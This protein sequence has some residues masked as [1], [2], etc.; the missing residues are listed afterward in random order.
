MTRIIDLLQH[1]GVLASKVRARVVA[2]LRR[3]PRVVQICWNGVVFELE[4][5]SLLDEGD[6]A[7]MACRGYDAILQRL[8]RRH[9]RHGDTFVD[10]GANVG[11]V[12]AFASSLVGSTGHVVGIEPLTE[13]YDRLVRLEEMNPTRRLTFVKGAAGEAEGTAQ[14][15]LNPNGDARNATLAR[16]DLPESRDVR[17]LRLDGLLSAVCLDVRKVSV[18]KID[19]EGFELSVIKGL[20]GMLDHH[21]PIM[22]CEL[23]PWEWPSL[24]QSAEEF[25]ALLRHYSYATEDPLT[26]RPREI[27][28]DFDTLVFR[29]R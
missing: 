20:V 3:P 11:F 19:V 12:S 7:A 27:G 24:G 25:R 13:F 14:I 2:R 10:V 26:G 21:R 4:R 9:L 5:S 29:P 15:S 22:V 8:L 16:D 6:F 17:V 28:T 23:K 1:P 18:I